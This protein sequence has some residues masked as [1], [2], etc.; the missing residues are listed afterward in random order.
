MLL[1]AFL[2]R[3]NFKT[4]IYGWDETIYL[5]HAEIISGFKENNFDEFYFRPLPISIMIAGIYKIYHDPV[6]ANILMAILGTLTVAIIFLIC[7]KIANEK[8]AYVSAFVTALWPIHIYYSKL[9]L[10]HI[11]AM[12][13]SAL[14]LY[15][16]KEG[17]EKDKLF[18]F[19]L[20]GLFLGLT[21]LTRFTYLF[22]PI[23]VLANIYLF[24]EKYNLKKLILMA[25]GFSIFTLPYLLWSYYEFSDPLYPIKMARTIVSW[26]YESPINYYLLHFPNV[27]GAFGTIGII[28]WIYLKRKEKLN[29]NEIVLLLWIFLFFGLIHTISHKEERYLMPL[30]LPTMILSS[31]G[32]TEIA[33]KKNSVFL[34]LVLI[35]P[36]FILLQP[37]YM[38]DLPCDNPAK[39]AAIWINNYTKGNCLIYAQED[40][41]HLA[42][43]SNCEVRLAPYHRE[44]F[45]KNI[46]YYMDK[47]GYYV[48]SIK[49]ENVKE[50]P[51]LSELMKNEHFELMKEI[52]ETYIFKYIP[53]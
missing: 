46:T 47:E 48:Y 28:G 44:E 35:I 45:F 14:M 23:I 39:E 29:K 16:L 19:F 27:L 6:I 53:K 9:V 8:V 10:T 38:T 20:S 15:F 17:E 30:L 3:L 25:L 22:L 4:C 24:R 34:L 32:V 13:F 26:T 2:L 37:T 49:Q 42:Y 51:K 31:I 52:N 11:P 5:Q 41:P 7:K 21:I 50:F 12:F 43:Y 36:L 18:Y 40:V 33:R 1:F